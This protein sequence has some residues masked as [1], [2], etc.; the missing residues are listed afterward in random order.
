V[1]TTKERDLGAPS[2]ASSLACAHAVLAGE[3][4]PELCGA[5]AWVTM[6]PPPLPELVRE[7]ARPAPVPGRNAAGAAG[8][9]S[10]AVDVS[11]MFHTLLANSED[12]FAAIAPEAGFIYLSPS[13][14]HLL[15]FRPDELLG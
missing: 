12:V 6:K 1:A 9:A 14:Q 11:R 2:L 13:V 7:L 5:R 8:A 3:R 10:Q 4:R 15:G